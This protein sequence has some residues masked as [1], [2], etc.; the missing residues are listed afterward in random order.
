MKIKLRNMLL[1]ALALCLCAGI[2]CACGGDDV[3]DPGMEAVAS[4]V[5]GSFDTD[6]LA[7]IPDAYVENMMQIPLNG[8]VSRNTVISA[9]DTNID[10]YGIF[11]GKDEAQTAELKAALEEYLEYRREL[12]ANDDL[13]EEK[14]KLDSAEV[15]VEGNY[16]MYAILDDADREA[17]FKAFTGC[18]E[19]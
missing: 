7:Q 17:V 9:V 18:F 16:V 5:F 6:D 15:W 3:K 14:P 10:E 1:I 8:Y 2:L 19:G 12:W 4:A 13:P 11:Q